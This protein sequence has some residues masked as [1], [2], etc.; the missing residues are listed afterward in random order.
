MG[1]KEQV[2]NVDVSGDDV[3]CWYVATGFLAEKKASAVGRCVR[4]SKL[5]GEA[6]RLVKA[7]APAR[8]GEQQ[9]GK[10]QGLPCTAIRSCPPHRRL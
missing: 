2:C 6:R 8:D 9:R 7:G 5:T 4:Q 10:A 3:L 1:G